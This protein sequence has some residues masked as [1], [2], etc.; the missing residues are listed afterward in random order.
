M[1]QEET[2]RLTKNERIVLQALAEKGHATTFLRV[3]PS[4]HGLHPRSAGV[5]ARYL[6]KRGLVRLFKSTRK[7]GAQEWI[8]SPAGK[9]SL[10]GFDIEANGSENT[11][12]RE[13]IMP[14]VVPPIPDAEKV[15][16]VLTDEQLARLFTSRV[17][18]TI[19][20]LDQERAGRRAGEQERVDLTR[21]M[22]DLEQQVVKLTEERDT[23]LSLADEAEARLEKVGAFL[24]GGNDDT[25]R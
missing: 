9:E 18:M 6:E 5:I 4:L 13:P 17:H 16:C 23:A 21:R 14:L 25:P 3:R 12:T 10:N 20:Q 8:I 7:G 24:K 1:I 11:A 2:V 19:S 15:V 22:S